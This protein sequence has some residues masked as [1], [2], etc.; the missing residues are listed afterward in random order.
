[1]TVEDLPPQVVG[2]G[3]GLVFAPMGAPGSMGGVAAT[4]TTNAG[5]GASVATPT[6]TAQGATLEDALREPEKRIIL[7]ALRASG[8]NKMKAAEKL[9]INRTTLYKKMR[10]LGIDPGRDALAG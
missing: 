5:A 1:M 9:G 4:T 3:G 8:N 10:Q 7:E 6:P 2:G